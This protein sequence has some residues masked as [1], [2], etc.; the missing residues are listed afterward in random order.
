MAKSKFDTSFNFG[1]NVSGKKSGSGSTKKRKAGKR[2]LSA[3]Q[4]ATAMF[5][6]KPRR[7]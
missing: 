2:K 5:Y 7:R 3:A 1:A 6:M 4:K